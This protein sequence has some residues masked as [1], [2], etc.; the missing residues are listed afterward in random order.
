LQI[1]A[2][3]CA[4]SKCKFFFTISWGLGL[5]VV[6]SSGDICG[7]ETQ[8]AATAI[9]MSLDPK[10]S[11]D[12]MSSGAR[13][14]PFYAELVRLSD[15]ILMQRLR[16]GHHDALAVLFD[17]YHRLV[18]NIALRILRDAGEAEDLMQSV[19][20]EIFRCAAQFD[21]ARGTVKVWI[22]Q[23]AYHRGFNRRQYLSLR[24][25]YDHQEDLALL[26]RS[27][28][29]WQVKSLGEVESAQAV[30]QA[31]K[32]LNKAQRSTLELA[33]YEGLT[34][35]E[36]AG[37]TG[38]SFDSVRHHYYRG[39]EKLKAVNHSLGGVPSG[40]RWSLFWVQTMA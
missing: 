34:M 16:D 25:I 10:S 29:A 12:T 7:L 39:L 30:R 35:R 4:T 18:L 28:A 8:A 23:Y 24:G 33:F 6:N 27:S 15:E 17:R 19:F 36:I 37:P 26:E 1:S 38:E 21:P 2:A 14:L 11:L 9:V 20:L 5:N 3:I 31:L 22:L 13:Q 32:H 40:A